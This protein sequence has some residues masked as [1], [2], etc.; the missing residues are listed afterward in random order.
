MIITADNKLSFA[1]KSEVAQFMYEKPDR[2]IA[3]LPIGFDRTV[4]VSVSIHGQQI[5][6]NAH[7]PFE[8]KGDVAWKVYEQLAQDPQD[9]FRIWIDP[10]DGETKYCAPLREGAS[11]ELDQA[12]SV[13]AVSI[14]KCWNTLE[15]F[16]KLAAEEPE[17]KPK[18]RDDDDPIASL[19]SLLGD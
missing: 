6:L 18:S 14:H 15:D 8:L 2:V 10:T 12:L 19:L 3:S 1:L 16:A 7:L 4:P 9:A 13:A 11:E 17:S 5:H